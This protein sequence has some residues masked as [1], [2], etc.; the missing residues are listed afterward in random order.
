MR[1]LGK[2]GEAIGA[3]LA[4]PLTILF[5]YL[6]YLVVA[7]SWDLLL[8]AAGMVVLGLTLF[9]IA[10]AFDEAKA[11]GT[12]R[13]SSALMRLL[14]T[15]GGHVARSLSVTCFAIA[16]G[17]VLAAIF[18]GVV[19]SRT[20]DIYWN[21]LKEFEE[22]LLYTKTWLDRALGLDVLAGILAVMVALSLLFPLRSL[23][24]RT[25]SVRRVFSFVYVALLT[26]TSFTFFSGMLLDRYELMLR[27][28]LRVQAIA[29]FERQNLDERKRLVAIAW[30]IDSLNDPNSPPLPDTENIARYMKDIGYY[31]AINAAAAHIAGISTAEFYREDKSRT[32]GRLEREVDI[33]AEQM[34][35]NEGA[36]STAFA[37]LRDAMRSLLGDT[38]AAL[39]ADDKPGAWAYLR[40]TRTVEPVERQGGERSPLLQARIGAMEILSS[41]VA[42]KIGHAV[43]S[44]EV[45][46]QFVGSLVEAV[47]MPLWDVVLPLDIDSLDTARGF[48][49][50]QQLS[51]ATPLAWSKIAELPEHAELAA[52]TPPPDTGTGNVPTVGTLGASI[53]NALPMPVAPSWEQFSGT[54]FVHRPQPGTPEVYTRPVFRVR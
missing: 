29:S 36:A 7:W 39:K 3:L 22:G 21:R 32:D 54:A 15:I 17:L 1:S 52:P 10:G 20:G 40:L 2:I 18:Q 42:E 8:W 23:I 28:P 35:P 27:Q 4:I 51:R 53:S 13:G 49:A 48:I 45:A 37:P 44:N 30:I 43:T 24:E 5:F 6:A 14:Q 19:L 46:Y 33:H 38:F 26:L 9:G 16:V 25:L 50:S 11:E 12:K 31:D 41:L 34:A 47:V